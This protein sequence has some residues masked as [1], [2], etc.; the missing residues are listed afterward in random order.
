MNEDVFHYVENCL[1]CQTNFLV[2]YATLYSITPTPRCSSYIVEYLKEGHVD[3]NKPKHRQHL[4]EIEATN[5]ALIKNQLYH[6]GEDGNLRLCVLESQYLEILHH[7][8]VGIFGGHF[9]GPTTTNTI[10][11]SGLW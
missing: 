10:L 2:A 1:I 5:Y 9:L 7:A 11:W 8:H 3:P 4:I 6:R